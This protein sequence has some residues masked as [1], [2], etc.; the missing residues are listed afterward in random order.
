MYVQNFWVINNQ[1]PFWWEDQL[2]AIVKWQVGDVAFNGGG[3]VFL[4]SKF[5]YKCNTVSSFFFQVH[6]ASIL[7]RRT[8]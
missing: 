8:D 7:Y 4:Q 1:P 5:L 6:T 3:G 2:S